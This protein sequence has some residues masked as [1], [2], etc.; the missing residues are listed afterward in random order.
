MADLVTQFEWLSDGMWTDFPFAGTATDAN[1]KPLTEVV[2]DAYITVHKAP[3]AYLSLVELAPE[4]TTWKIVLEDDA[5][6]SYLLSSAPAI[7]RG[8]WT[9][10]S[11]ESRECSARILLLSSSV[12]SIA[13]TA[14]LIRNGRLVPHATGSAPES[15][16]SIT[17]EGVT[18]SGEVVLRAGHNVALTPATATT[19][20]TGRLVTPVT[21]A[22]TAGAGEGPAPCTDPACKTPLL[23]INNVSPNANG[24]FTIEGDDCY[25]CDPKLEE[26]LSGLLT[27]AGRALLT[28]SCSPCCDCSDY[29]YMYDEVLRPLATRLNQVATGLEEERERYLEVYQRYLA[30]VACKTVPSMELKTTGMYNRSASVAL[31]ISNST[32]SGWPDVTGE[33]KVKI[34]PAPRLAPGTV[35][36]H[37][38][39]A[40]SL[41]GHSFDEGAGEMTLRVTPVPCCTTVWATFEVIWD[42]TGGFIDYQVSS[43]GILGGLS[44][45]LSARDTTLLPVNRRRE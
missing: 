22:A 32:D 5:G 13:W 40:G 14:G 18:L 31:G 9:I 16:T 21:L 20:A 7:E 35:E 44:Y 12:S 37:G 24:N 3:F 10:I 6:N 26:G 15:V 17:A 39:P 23:T 28:N 34:T 42:G 33:V 30:I 2:V 38:H 4:G 41:I 27:A 29:E 11:G 36:L 43:S 45:S 8:P 19:T 1:D 25:A